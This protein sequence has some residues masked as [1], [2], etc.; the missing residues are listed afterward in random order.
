MKILGTYDER[1][2]IGETEVFYHHTDL[3]EIKD[4]TYVIDY[5]KNKQDILSLSHATAG[6][7]V[8]YSLE[9]KYTLL[10]LYEK[11]ANERESHK[12]KELFDLLNDYEFAL[13]A[14][15]EIDGKILKYVS[16]ELNNNE[17]FVQEVIKKDVDVLEYAPKDI[18][19]N[20]N[21]IL[22]AV[23]ID[24]DALYYASNELRNDGEV[25]LAAVKNTGYALQFASDEL[26]NDKEIVLTAVSGQGDALEYASDEL[27]DDVNIVA[28]A[29][30]TRPKA[31]KYA[32]YRLQNMGHGEIL[33]V[34]R[35]A[36]S[37]LPSR[38]DV[39]KGNVN[40]DAFFEADEKSQVGERRE[41]PEHTKPNNGHEEI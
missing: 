21:V 26:K 16:D 3:Y 40:M 29:I 30:Q 13:V 17:K 38:E 2:E 31:I 11:Y 9:S 14:V 39:I 32:S 8:S 35:E 5:G 10:E 12:H 27:R 28:T 15:T 1:P 7:G 18:K 34:A 25:V 41:V 37:P 6:D 19:N 4:A 36:A 33:K 22:T 23:N 20:K 24:G